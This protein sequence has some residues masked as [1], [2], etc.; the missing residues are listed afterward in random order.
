ML[1]I[2]KTLQSCSLK[3]I[4]LYLTHM[5]RARSHIAVGFVASCGICKVQTNYYQLPTA[6]ATS[7]YNESAQGIP[8]E[9]W[10]VPRMFVGCE[11]VCA[12]RKLV[13]KRGFNACSSALLQF[14]CFRG[15][16]VIVQGFFFTQ[17]LNLIN[18]SIYIFT[19]SSEPAIRSESS[20]IIFHV[21]SD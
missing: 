10:P 15:Q 5:C 7:S 19:R 21:N 4:F 9:K 14:N 12:Q 20:Q 2:L 11:R 1:Y 18:L 8:I 3:Y 17:L 6:S 16:G 13:N